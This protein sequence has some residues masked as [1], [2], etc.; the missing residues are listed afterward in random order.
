MRICVESFGAISDALPVGNS[1]APPVA[2][3]SSNSPTTSKPDDSRSGTARQ[4]SSNKTLGT[5]TVVVGVC[6]VLL[7]IA[8]FVFVRQRKKQNQLDERFSLMHPHTGLLTAPA[9]QDGTIKASSNATLL[10]EMQLGN[11]DVSTKKKLGI[12]GLWTAEYQGTPVVAMRINPRAGDTSIKQLN[13]KLNQF[14]PLKHP[15]VVQFLGI[16]RTPLD[17][18]L[19]VVENME[20]GSLRTVLA[21]A[22]VKLTWEQ[23]L[24]MAIDIASGVEFMHKQ[25]TALHAKKFTA[26]TVLCAADF[27]CKLDVFE[28]APSLRDSSSPLL[29]FG[30]NEIASRAPELLNGGAPTMASDVYALGVLLCE[31]STRL[32]AYNDILSQKGSTIG[33]LMIAREVRGNRLRPKPAEDAPTGYQE[34]INR[35]VAFA[36]NAR[37]SASEVVRALKACNS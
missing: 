26:A 31:L 8:A 18:Y 34:V 11:E 19:V 10:G 29:S 6:C 35:C 2:R 22:Q 9:T 4:T 17:E 20:C 21:D 25:P 28:Y 16:G 37:P 15:N 12:N 24:K 23:R 36:P 30:F 7:V 5:V 14:I 13:A 1:P 33:D 27:T 3:P 32:P